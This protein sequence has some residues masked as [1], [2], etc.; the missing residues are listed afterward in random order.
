MLTNDYIRAASHSR[1]IGSIPSSLYTSQL[2]SS[3]LILRY[4]WEFE[5]DTR[6]HNKSKTAIHKSFKPKHIFGDYLSGMANR[7]LPKTVSRFICGSHWLRCATQ[8]CPKILMSSSA[9][10]AWKARC[11][12]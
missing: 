9:L 11:V 2:D 3:D 6:K 12:W 10:P 7:Q 1:I 4:I 8:S 5:I